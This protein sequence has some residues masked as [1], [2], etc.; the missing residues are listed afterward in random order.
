M[1]FWPRRRPARA[2]K[3]V[4]SFR[5]RLE[6]LEDR[7]VPSIDLVANLSG[8]AAVQD[9]LPWWVVHANTGDTIQFAGNL[10]GGTINLGNYL[11]ITKDLNIDGASNGITVNGGGL[12]VFYVEAGVN[13]AIT[14]LT[15]AGGGAPPGFNGGGIFNKGS[16]ALL[17]STVA[18]N[19]A[20]AS[21]GIYNA[22]GATMTMSGDT[23]NNNTAAGAG[24]GIGNAGQMDIIN[25]TIALNKANK[26]GGI[27][28]IGILN[29]VSST[30]ADNTVF[31]TG[32]DGGGI[33]TYGGADQLTLLNTIVFNPNSG[34]ATRNE[35]YGTITQAQGDL[36]GPGIIKVAPGGDHGGGFYGFNPHLGLLR[37]N[38]GP[39]ATM[40][41]LPGS[42]AIGVGATTSA[43]PGLAVESVD[44]RGDPR[45]ANSI[46]IGA[47]QTQSTAAVEIAGAGVWRYTKSA[48]WV[49][50]TPA[51][52]S[53]LATDAN[54]DVAVQIAGAG[55]WRYTD[56]G[57][58][59]QLTTANASLLA[60][61]AYGDVAVEIP[62]AGVWR[63]TNG[64][65]WAQ[66]TVGNASLL[67]M[68]A[69]GDVAIEIPGA[70][71][72][73]YMQGAGWGQL[74]P[75]D[76]SLLTMGADGNV[77]V[78]I[79]GAG[80]WRY[81]A[82]T[83]WM[84]L[85]TANASALAM[86]SNGDVTAEIAGAGVWRYTDS[87]NWTQL[88]TADASALVMD[89]AAEVFALLPGAGLWEYSGAWQQLT[90]GDA[91]LLGSMP[92]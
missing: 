4:S 20:D 35:V 73:R 2:V 51:D 50:L 9:S 63:Y 88:T 92:S 85:T 79:A 76:A 6:A 11:D 39:T 32:A 14:G 15:I 81:E 62:G 61:D 54:G 91:V 28:N 17:N 60:M 10:N 90:T 55:V 68:D 24:G 77:A 84:Q 43:I 56:G 66:L 30:V 34:A 16:L 74:T 57:G 7:C 80:V 67:A 41:L 64:T 27:A 58:W 8:S 75:A 19:F 48:G 23:V 5:P 72:W 83:G 26:G 33:Y 87:V 59:A 82:A 1:H 36:F 52:A 70:G 89:S 37:N 71:V 44:Q 12:R 25:C 21:A 65:G 69:N 31:G 22:G 13:V 47:F 46:D 45:P 86:D 42:P 38:G 78:E 40:A 3:A 18:G 53:L 29:V 49:Q